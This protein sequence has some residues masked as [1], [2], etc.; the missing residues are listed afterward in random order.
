MEYNSY[1]L[2]FARSVVSN[3]HPYFARARAKH[4]EPDMEWIER[5]LASP[6]KSDFD[7]EHTG[8]LICYGYIPEAGNGKWLVVIAQN[9]QLFN[10]YFN[11]DLL[12]SWGRPE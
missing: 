12:R 8:R 11:R 6:H 9:E 7:N 5:T 2:E 1:G 10:A 4:P 3:P